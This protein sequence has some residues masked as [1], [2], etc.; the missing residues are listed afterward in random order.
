MA[1]FSLPTENSTEQAGIDQDALRQF[2]AG[3]A[4]HSTGT[5]RPWDNLDPN[6]KPTKNVSVRLNEHEL[7]ILQYLSDCEDRSQSKLLRSWVMPKLNEAK[8]E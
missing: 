5:A 7:A 1:D 6:A 3:A 2:T 8:A 4:T